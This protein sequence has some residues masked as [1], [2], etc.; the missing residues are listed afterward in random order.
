MV[1]MQL[2]ARM[3][4][5]EIDDLPAGVPVSTAAEQPGQA[6][7]SRDRR[8]LEATQTGRSL[9]VAGKTAGP[10][11]YRRRVAG[12]AFAGVVG[13]PVRRLHDEACTVQHHHHHH[14][15]H[16][17]LSISNAAN[18]KVDPRSGSPSRL[19]RSSVARAPALIK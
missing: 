12:V 9:V 6:T 16:H 13:V 4:M 3:M 19:Q 11:S 10:C 7:S 18:V 1:T 14:H 5:L 15:H 2:R 8:Q 17:A